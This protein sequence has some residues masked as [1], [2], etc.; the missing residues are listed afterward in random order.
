MKR[1]ILLSALALASLLTLA[2]CSADAPAPAGNEA[3]PVAVF[4][5]ISDATP[6]SAGLN[7][8]SAAS[9]AT[10]RDHDLFTMTDT[11]FTNN[12]AGYSV[13]VPAGLSVCDM[14]DATYRSTL[15]NADASTRLEIFTQTLSD[16]VDAASYLNYSNR[17]LENTQDFTQTYDFSLDD[18]VGGRAT[19]IFT[20]ERRALARVAG[21]RN[22]YGQ[23]DIVDGANV[24]SF[25]LTS[26]SPVSGDTLRA[27]EES[28]QSFTPTATAA[29]FPRQPRQRSDITDET[30]D[31]YERIFADDADCTW[32]IYEPGVNG[33]IIDDLLALQ[34]TLDH[35][36]DIVLCYSDLYTDY[37]PQLIYNTLTRLWENGSVVELTLQPVKYDPATN[38]NIVYDILDGKYDEFLH[39]Y[40]ADVAR[41][42][43]P[44]L[45][46]PFN[47]MNGDW[48]TYS[49]YWSA[50][51]C[52]TYVELYRYVYSIFE[53]EGAN[54][55]TL[56]IWNPNE[57]SFPNFCWNFVDNYYPGDEYVDIVGLTG[58][59]TGDYYEGETWRSFDEIYAPLYA[60]IAPQYQQ[61]L[62]ITEFACS[63]I[64]G[65]K[66]VW[67]ADMFNHIKNYP[68]IK[69]AVWWDSADFDADGT[70]ARDYYIDNNPAVVSVFKEHLAQLDKKEHP[71]EHTDALLKPSDPN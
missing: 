37:T 44:V 55:N 13:D 64:G 30:R 10:A 62:M 52:S 70:I 6:T 43:H 39:D 4:E 2:G 29:E 7:S 18:T 56:W 69:A 15:E 31:L 48:C 49:A 67:I 71:E 28:F 5:E 63:S 57:K 26:T 54:K 45:F 3:T 68:H 9:V 33:A 58:Y 1:S 24:Y 53:E 14:G 20:W 41:F 51:D 23:L 40:A 61:P 19:H 17:F 36:F 34:N 59:N 50:R 47:E 42:G 21:D 46:R 16:D 11:T 8:D 60:Q 38:A 12:A 25:L 35:Q 65:D 32:G 66:A 22:Y 27:I